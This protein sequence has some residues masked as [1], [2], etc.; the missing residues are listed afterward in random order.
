M[1]PQSESIGD[2][3]EDFLLRQIAAVADGDFPSLGEAVSKIKLSL[4]SHFSEKI[5]LSFLNDL[6]KCIFVSPSKPPNEA[7]INLVQEVVALTKYTTTC[8]YGISQF[9]YNL[10]SFLWKGIPVDEPSQS[11]LEKWQQ[12]LEQLQQDFGALRPKNFQVADG[13]KPDQAAQEIVENLYLLTPADIAK[14][15]PD[16]CNAILRQHMERISQIS[17]DVSAQFEIGKGYFKGFDAALN[18][19]IRSR[20]LITPEFE[21]ALIRRM[22][23]EG[24]EECPVPEEGWKKLGSG[25]F[26]VVW[27]GISEGKPICLKMISFEDEGILDSSLANLGV[28]EKKFSHAIGRNIAAK[29][30]SDA[31][32]PNFG[33]L[34]DTQPVYAAHPKTGKLGVGISMAIAGGR[35]ISSCRPECLN[36]W[37]FVRDLTN[38]QILD[39]LIGVDD[40]HAANCFYNPAAEADRS[41]VI[42]IDNDQCLAPGDIHEV[43]EELAH[44]WKNKA[45]SSGCIF[46]MPSVISAS[47]AAFLGCTP[48]ALAEIQTARDALGKAVENFAQFNGRNPKPT[49]YAQ[50]AAQHLQFPIY[51]K[52]LKARIDTLIACSIGKISAPEILAMLERFLDMSQMVTSGNIALLGD[53]DAASWGSPAV[54]ESLCTGFSV[55]YDED[56]NIHTVADVPSDAIAELRE[57]YDIVSPELKY[58]NWKKKP[59]LMF[60]K[61]DMFREYFQVSRPSLIGRDLGE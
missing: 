8:C 27:H 13:A 46:S 32:F 7:L 53:S 19:A 29:S 6:Q 36:D 1:A 48:E 26:S 5:D 55:E 3:H 25:A 22:I 4:E 20:A 12:R 57:N 15:P 10:S 49:E 54:K 24:A 43:A 23:M 51:E 45:S 30:I 56:G 50:L 60:S 14:I 40:R 39:I 11:F 33:I 18:K 59:V 2:L 28:S 44:A 61:Y 31:M 34:V 35:K 38:L 58:L 52:E 37:R 47:V 17:A 42:G 21:E 41:C 9:A 16:V